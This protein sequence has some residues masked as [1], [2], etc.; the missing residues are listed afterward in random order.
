V[1][2]SSASAGWIT[3]EDV[4]LDVTARFYQCGPH[5]SSSVVVTSV[6]RTTPGSDAPRRRATLGRIAF[7]VGGAAFVAFWTW[8][9]FFADKTALNKIED[10]AWAARAETICTPVKAELRDLDRQTSTDLAVRADLVVQSTDM[11]ARMVDDIGSVSPSDE[12]GRELVPQWLDDYRTLI[13]D[14]YRYADDLRNGIN[15]AFSETPVQGVPITERLETFA[16][17]NE[18]SSCAPP[19]GSIL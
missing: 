12:K 18:M 7:L 11:L 14:R 3:P 9:L 17:D 19:R 5:V 2:G 6:E 13:A 1:D 16:A 10:R 4:S 8:A 15:R